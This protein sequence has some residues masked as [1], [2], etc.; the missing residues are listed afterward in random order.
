MSRSRR[1]YR[2][3]GKDQTSLRLTELAARMYS[4]ADPLIIREF[5]GEDGMLYDI[6]GVIEGDFM[7]ELAV[8]K[9]LEGLADEDGNG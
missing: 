9:A 6:D 5:D 7:S 1:P 3:Y 8:N 4:K 2:I